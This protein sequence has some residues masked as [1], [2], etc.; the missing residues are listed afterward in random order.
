MVFTSIF[1]LLQC[2]IKQITPHVTLF[3]RISEG[4]NITFTRNLRGTSYQIGVLLNTTGFD[5]F[6]FE[7][8]STVLES[9]LVSTN[10][11]FENIRI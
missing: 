1:F 10:M 6:N 5:V 7:Q 8:F 11:M 2:D 9:V 3:S 4:K